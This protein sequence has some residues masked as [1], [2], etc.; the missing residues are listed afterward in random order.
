MAFGILFAQTKSTDHTPDLILW[1]VA[2]TLL[3]TALLMAWMKKGGSETQRS[4]WPPGPI[5]VVTVSLQ[6]L[7]CAWVLVDVVQ[8]L[9][10]L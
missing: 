10:S 9:H 4:Q 7:F 2:I 1:L 3:I 6:V 8:H 5:S